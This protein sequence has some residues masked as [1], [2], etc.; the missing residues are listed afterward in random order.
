MN[1][2]VQLGKLFGKWQFDLPLGGKKGLLSKSAKA[3]IIEKF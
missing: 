1:I 2:A 3:A